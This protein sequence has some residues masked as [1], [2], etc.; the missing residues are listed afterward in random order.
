MILQWTSLV[1]RST[2][3]SSIIPPVGMSVGS[4]TVV[5]AIVCH[6]GDDPDSGHYQCLFISSGSC[7][8]PDDGKEAIRCP[9]V[10]PIC[11]SA[12]LIPQEDLNMWWR[13]PI[14]SP[15]KICTLIFPIDLLGTAFSGGAIQVYLSTFA[16]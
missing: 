3:R 9:V 7:W 10:N 13:R 14:G 1:P 15:S 6:F 5:V 16:S 8:M 2:Y 11:R 12:Y 4:N